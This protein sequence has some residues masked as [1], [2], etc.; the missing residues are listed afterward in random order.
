[1]PTSGPLPPQ[2]RIGLRLSGRRPARPHCP[3]MRAGEVIGEVTSGTFSPTLEER[4]RWVTFVKIGR[5]R[6]PPGGRRT[7]DAAPGA[8]RATP[9]LPTHAIRKFF[10]DPQQLKFSNTHEWVAFTEEAG[11]RVATV[12]ISARL[13]PSRCLPTWSTSNYPPSKICKTR[14]IVG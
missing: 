6:H 13:P 5:P 14:T 11:E 1:M 4:S 3:I 2:R 10:M 8:R 7:W 12:G 9:L